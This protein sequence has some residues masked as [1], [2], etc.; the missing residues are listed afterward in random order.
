[1]Q[2]MWWWLTMCVMWCAVRLS[3]RL[4]ACL[5]VCMSV[6]VQENGNGNGGEA[7]ALEACIA[8][9]PDAVYF[10]GDGSW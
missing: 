5:P 6:C 4:S 9:A 3:D 7:A 8:M 1:M 10:L 2:V